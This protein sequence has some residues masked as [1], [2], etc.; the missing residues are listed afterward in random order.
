MD[1]KYLAMTSIILIY[2]DSLPKTTQKAFK[3]FF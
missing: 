3:A 1:T 2:D